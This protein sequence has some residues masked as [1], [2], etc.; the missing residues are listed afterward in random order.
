MTTVSHAPRTGEVAGSVRDSTPDEVARAVERAARAA[1]A[2]AQTPPRGRRTWLEALAQ[3]LEDHRDEL[4]RLADHETALGVPRLRGELDRAADQLRFY[5]D[6]AV[7]GSFVGLTRDGATEGRPEL[8]R[9]HV[10]LGPVAVFGASNF[11]FGFGVLGND[12][13]SALAAGCPVVVKAH[14][15]HALLCARLAELAETALRQA[16]APAGTF[17]QVSGFDAGRRLV[18][19]PSVRAVGFTG[20]QAGGLALWRAAN[21]RDVV[22]PVYAEM[23]TVNPV[24]M[25]PAAVG[26]LDDVVTGFVGSFTLGAGQFCTKPGLLLAPQGRGVAEAVARALTAASPVPTMLTEAIAAAASDGVSRLREAGAEVVAAVAGP[27]AG[28]STD[29]VVLS[30]PAEALRPGSALLEECFG[31]VAVVVEYATPAEAASLLGRLQGSLT[32]TVVTSGPDDPDAADLVVSASRQVGRVTVDDWPTGVA[33]TWA[34]QHGGP[35]PATSHP[36]STSVGA[37]ALDR[38]VRPVSYQ[39]VPDAWLPE[40]ARVAN[41]WELPRRIDGRLEQ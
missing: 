14:P 22:I 5:A 18:E 6:V 28:W 36:A 25:T 17:G 2:V 40:A 41:P 3:V 10:P 4:V 1:A 7:E 20:S 26:R 35:W 30:A 21:E 34:Q 9:L 13:A 38:F 39:S 15:A 11:P 19:H 33:W 16:G 23:G 37:A 8:V 32:A 27:G 12:T 24:V 31:P 29:A